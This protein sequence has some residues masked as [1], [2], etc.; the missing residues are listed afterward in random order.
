MKKM[1][2]FHLVTPSP[3]PLAASFSILGLVSSTVVFNQSKIFLPLIGSL[4][5]C[6]LASFMWWSDIFKE[7][8][9]EGNHSL[10]IIKGLKIGMIFFIASEV[11]LFFSFF[12]GYYHNSL[13]PSV[14]IGV[15]WPPEGIRPFHPFNIPLMNT[16]LLLSSG[17]SVT[18]SHCSMMSKDFWQAKD[19]LLITMALGGYFTYLQSVEYC[20][21]QFSMWDS[22]YGSC[23]YFGTGLHG[24]HV[25]VGTIFLGTSYYQMNKLSCT[26]NHMV[27]YECAIWYWH[28]VDVVWVGLY[29]AIYLWKE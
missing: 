8:T 21:A 24:M 5:C 26:F 25:I 19:S 4:M 11:M 15:C 6:L 12:W 17:A 9:M 22:V 2:P 3:W 28:F 29:Y 10:L 1:H 14:E 27:G 16:F 23:F 13:N 20:S 18:W 7:S